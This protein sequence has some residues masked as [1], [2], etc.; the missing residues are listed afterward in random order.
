MSGL[1]EAIE[2]LEKKCNSLNE[3]TS[4]GR[5]KIN[6]L[7]EAIRVLKEEFPGHNEFELARLLPQVVKVEF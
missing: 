1:T 2:G 3:L 7:K 4:A 5:D 6:G